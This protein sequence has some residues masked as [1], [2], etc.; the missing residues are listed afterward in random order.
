MP[1]S[2]HHGSHWSDGKTTQQQKHLT[3]ACSIM[4]SLERFQVQPKRKR[5]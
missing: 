3:M 1:C 5:K 2:G 4:R